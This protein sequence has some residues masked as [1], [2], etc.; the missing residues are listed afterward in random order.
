MCKMPSALLPTQTPHRDRTL[1]SIIT[2]V[3]VPDGALVDRLLGS[4]ARLAI[5]WGGTIEDL[6]DKEEIWKAMSKE[7]KDKVVELHKAKS[8]GCAVKDASIAPTGTAPIDV[9]DQLQ[10]LTC[11]VQSLDSSRDGGRQSTV[12]HVPA[13]VGIAPS[14]GVHVICMALISWEL[15]LGAISFDGQDRWS[16]WSPMTPVGCSPWGLVLL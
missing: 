13:D 1:R 9:S 4:A 5:K 2:L 3:E 6:R 10:T 16:G 12:T 15:M 11:A 14:L 8:T 7:Q